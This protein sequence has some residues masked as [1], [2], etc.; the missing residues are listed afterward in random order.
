M[1]RVEVLINVLKNTETTIRSWEFLVLSRMKSTYFTKKSKMYFADLIMFIL[2]FTKKTLQI[3][4]D[5]FIKEIKNKDMTYTKQALSKARKK[6]SPWAFIHIFVE[7]VKLFYTATDL[8]TYKGYNLLA[9]DGSTSELPKN[10]EEL[11]EYFGFAS[12]GKQEIAMARTSGLYDVEN[13]VM[14]DAIIGRYD[15]DERTLAKE[16]I[17]KIKGYGLKN[18]LVLFDRGYASKEMIAYM[19]EK[20]IDFVMRVSTSFIKE[21]NQ[22]KENDE[23][24]KVKHEEK[25]LKIRV[26]KVILETGEIETLITSIMYKEF[27]P[28][29]FKVLYF[30]RWGIEVKYNEIK[31]RLQLENYT[32]EIPASIEQDFYASMYL[33]NLISFAKMISDDEIEERNQEKE[34]KYEYKTN[35]NILIGKLKN[36]LVLMMIEQN[37][38]RRVEMLQDIMKEIVRNVIPVRPDRRNPRQKKFSR[39]KYPM[40]RKSAL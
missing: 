33:I 25:D 19:Y 34:L 29:D 6:I 18:S 40:N 4:I 3:E 8:R 11:R 35:V 10:T 30:K 12:N 39:N 16:H 23:V 20:N 24:V 9:I 17:E 1:T 38:N 32:A 36:N 14:V 26:I 27:A 22:V 28:E 7:N 5:S 37:E 21:V 31:S 13:N 15:I 2:N